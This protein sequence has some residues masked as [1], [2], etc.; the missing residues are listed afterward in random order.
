M[1]AGF[2]NQDSR[3]PNFRIPGVQDSK[4]QDSRIPNSRIPG[5]QEFRSSGF[6]DPVG[7]IDSVCGAHAR[8]IAP[9][10]AERNVVDRRADF[11]SVCNT[12]NSRCR[13]RSA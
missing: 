12:R 5:F 8:T 10:E 3:I 7:M 9:R 2:W 13:N 4:F 6:Q 1:S 11:R